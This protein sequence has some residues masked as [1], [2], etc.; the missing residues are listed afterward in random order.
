MKPNSAIP[1][2]PML[3]SGLPDALAAANSHTDGILSTQ[4]TV[5]AANEVAHMRSMDAPIRALASS[6]VGDLSEA[7]SQVPMRV[8]VWIRKNV[9]YTQETP[10]VEILQGPYRTLGPTIKVQTPMGPFQFRGVGTGD[11]DDLSILFATLCRSVGVEAFLAGIAKT[12]RPDGFFH[13]MGYCNGMFYELSK[14]GPYG[15]RGGEQIAS[16][17]PYENIVATIYDPV[18]RKQERLRPTAKSTNMSGSSTMCGCGCCSLCMAGIDAQRPRPYTDAAPNG[19]LY[20]PTGQVGAYQP[21][22]PGALDSLQPRYSVPL[23]LYAPSRQISGISMD[24]THEFARG[25]HGGSINDSARG[26]HGGSLDLS[27]SSLNSPM[28]TVST[29]YQQ[30]MRGEA[31]SC[32][33]ILFQTKLAGAGANE[34]YTVTPLASSLSPTV[35]GAWEAI[36]KAVDAGQFQHNNFYVKQGLLIAVTGRKRVDLVY[37]LNA[38]AAYRSLANPNLVGLKASLWPG[39]VTGEQRFFAGQDGP[40]A[41]PYSVQDT[42]M[43]G[44][45]IA[46]IQKSLRKEA[47]V[48]LAA[49][50]AGTPPNFTAGNQ[51]QPQPYLSPP[52]VQIAPSYGPPKTNPL[53]YLP[54]PP[55][56]SGPPRLWKGDTQPSE[57]ADPG[58]SYMPVVYQPFVGPDGLTRLRVLIPADDVIRLPSNKELGLKELSKLLTGAFNNLAAKEPAFA[59]PARYDVLLLRAPYGNRTVADLTLT[60][61]FYDPAKGGGFET[62]LIND[63]IYDANS[64]LKVD[65]GQNLEMALT[66]HVADLGNAKT[67]SILQALLPTQYSM[68]SQ[69]QALA[70]LENVLAQIGG[71]LSAIKANKAQVSRDAKGYPISEPIQP[72]ALVSTVPVAPVK[73]EV[74]PPVTATPPAAPS[75]AKSGIHPLA[76]LALLGL[77]VYAVSK[78]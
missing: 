14:D 28:M 34:F 7:K 61:F 22:P 39:A 75:A 5:Q 8:A 47:E 52:V 59:Q 20:T 32:A 25:P 19:T 9:K 6:I 15:G 12:N 10:M 55:P 23:N 43:Y 46:T 62:V 51:P 1:H 68:L 16:E 57:P 30:S 42:S 53:P 18:R 35:Q 56:V 76:A 36:R 72:P 73:T 3:S 64:P 74:T 44:G 17:A 71:Q 26:P 69:E 2:L 21:L 38:G 13:A 54:P 4:Q 66:F 24:G 45:A 70:C 67:N 58:T 29:P 50:S 31:N 37:P 77:G 33:I 11:C 78:S 63:P 41:L 49:V 40:I 65:R 27:G 60:Q 48:L